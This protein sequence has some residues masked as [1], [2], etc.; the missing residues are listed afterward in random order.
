MRSRSRSVSIVT[1][2]ALLVT[3]GSA[4]LAS[5]QVVGAEA[6]GRLVAVGAGD[7]RFEILGS[8]GPTPVMRVSFFERNDDIPLTLEDLESFDAY[9]EE[10]GPVQLSEAQIQEFQLRVQSA[11]DSTDSSTPCS[12]E[13]F[14][15]CY[16]QAVEECEGGRMSGG[17]GAGVGT[18]LAAPSGPGGV[19]T[20]AIGAF[21]M[22]WLTCDAPVWIGCQVG[23]SS[24]GGPGCYPTGSCY[25]VCP[26]NTQP[27]R[28]T[29]RIGEER[30]QC[31]SWNGP[32][33][34]EDN[35]VPPAVC[36]DDGCMGCPDFTVPGQGDCRG[37][38][39]TSQCGEC[40][41]LGYP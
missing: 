39:G 17:I 19:L 14:D 30:G 33:P 37:N 7:V 27:T 11:M 29:C 2:C 32:G 25:E 13:E 24:G 1:V 12:P 26:E 28:Q 5:G 31:C 21:V 6:E 16:N 36:Y 35:C 20:G 40:C 18:R 10:N 3:S 38:N 22:N 34:V 9:V 4:R 23:C 41:I 8:E 15:A